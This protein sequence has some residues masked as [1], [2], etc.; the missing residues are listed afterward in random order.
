MAPTY[1][2][3]CLVCGKPLADDGSCPSCGAGSS[4]PSIPDARV[5][6]ERAQV[7]SP[8]GGALVPGRIDRLGV[9]QAAGQRTNWFVRI[10]AVIAAVIF[11][12]AVAAVVVAAVVA[13][14]SGVW[15]LPSGGLGAI[16]GTVIVLVSLLVLLVIG[17]MVWLLARRDQ[18][19][20]SG[21]YGQRRI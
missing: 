13:L 8:P 18:G 15:I 19:P 21:S 1:A 4:P 11:A 14:V 5:S 17:T 9:F 7:E 20:P 12:L 16:L 2:M 10:A 3:S 6:R